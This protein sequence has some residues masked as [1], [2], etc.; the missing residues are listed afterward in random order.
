MLFQFSAFEPE[1]ICAVK[2]CFAEQRLTSNAGAVRLPGPQ[3]AGKLRLTRSTND[4]L[5]GS[6]RASLMA[7][8]CRAV[9]LF[10]PPV[11]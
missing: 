10:H 6:I 2:V 4:N 7:I 8:S 1:F 9:A 5:R 11:S 3:A